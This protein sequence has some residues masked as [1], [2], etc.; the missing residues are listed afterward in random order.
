MESGQTLEA[1]AEAADVCPRT[2]C[3][4]VDRYRR[5]GLAGLQDRSS[6][7]HRLRRPTPQAVVEEIE[8]D[9]RRQRTVKSWAYACGGTIGL[10]KGSDKSDDSTGNWLQ[11]YSASAYCLKIGSGAARKARI[12]E[13]QASRRVEPSF[14]K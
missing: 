13:N 3:K 1:V 10:I 5:E 4:W 2:A 14:M 12:P 9:P 7:P 11:T 6:P 8:Q